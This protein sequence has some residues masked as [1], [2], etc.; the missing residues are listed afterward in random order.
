MSIVRLIAREPGKRFAVGSDQG[1]A[2]DRVDVDVRADR[3][4]ETRDDVDLD[5][6]LLQLADHAERLLV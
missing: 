5:I 2:F 4:E 6:E 1:D 3:L